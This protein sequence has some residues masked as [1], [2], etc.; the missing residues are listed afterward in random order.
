[1]DRSFAGMNDHMADIVTAERRLSAEQVCAYLQNVKHVSFATVNSRSEPIVAPLDGWF[2]HGRFVVS[3]GGGALR[4]RHLKTN[5]AVS[6]AHVNGDEIGVWAHGSART[7]RR[8]EDLARDWETAATAV[9]GSSPFTWGDIA[10][11][12]VEPRAMFAYAMDP[13]KF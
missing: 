6:L 8:D 9:Y 13:S 1:M 7:L 11:I 12:A 4:V 2:V 5:A 10:I 3:T